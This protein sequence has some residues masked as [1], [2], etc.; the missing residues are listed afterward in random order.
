M[1]SSSSSSFQRSTEEV[2][3]SIDW[4]TDTNLFTGGS[5]WIGL[6]FRHQENSEDTA[7]GIKTG[8]E[9]I[10]V[11]FLLGLLMDLFRNVEILEQ[12]ELVGVGYTEETPVIRSCCC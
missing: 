8:V 5:E 12:F 2:T 10:V 3:G 4:S 1:V 7:S 6:S 9:V 11:A